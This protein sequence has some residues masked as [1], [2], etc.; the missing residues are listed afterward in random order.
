MELRTARPADYAETEN[1]TREAFWNHYAPGCNEH[2]LLHIMRGSSSFIP[3][4]DVVA[5]LNGGIA[6]SSVCAKS[7]IRTDNGRECAVV[8]LGPISVLPECQRRGI[9]RRMLEYARARAREMGFRAILLYG[10]PDYYSRH[11]FMPAELWGI[12]TADDMY[13]AALQVCELQEGALSGMEGRYLEAAIYNIDE[14]RTA[15]FDRH[16]PVKEKVAG[17]PSQ[18]RFEELVA[19]RRKADAPS[20]G[21]TTL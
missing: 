9:G 10:D 7:I 5:V 20:A 16:F 19:M 1:V 3:E 4:L 18:Q 12:R 13:A 6:G 2:Y 8:T 17:T 21:G 14:K 15:E 11:G